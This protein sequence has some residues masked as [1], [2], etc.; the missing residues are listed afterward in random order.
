MHSILT[1]IMHRP[2][3]LQRPRG[4]YGYVPPDRELQFS[5]QLRDAARAR[6]LPFDLPQA[7]KYSRRVDAPAGVN[8][9]R[10]S[11]AATALITTRKFEALA[12][13]VALGQE[14]FMFVSRFLRSAIR[15][16][17]PGRASPALRP[18][19]VALTEGPSP[20]GAV[21]FGHVT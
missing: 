11:L 6:T 18:R 21:V 3:P 17:L 2:D 13:E 1:H 4:R 12:S 14:P 20:S 16:D 8:A 7:V 10:I 19:D 15:P 9:R 5:A